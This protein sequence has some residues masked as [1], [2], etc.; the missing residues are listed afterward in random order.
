MLN[1]KKAEG[2]VLGMGVIV[3]YEEDTGHRN[4]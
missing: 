3:S 4:K 2:E 1:A